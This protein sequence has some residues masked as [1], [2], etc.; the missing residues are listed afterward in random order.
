[1]TLDATMQRLQLEAARQQDQIESL[2]E[3]GAALLD[4]LGAAGVVS[5]E[6]VFAQVHRRRFAAARVSHPCPWPATSS[7]VLQTHELGLAISRTL[8]LHSWRALET[9]SSGT[10]ASVA[11]VESRGSL[12]TLFP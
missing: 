10:F 4:C 12:E 11:P 3:E 6:A 2:R 8:G 5:S 9:S 7:T 1:M